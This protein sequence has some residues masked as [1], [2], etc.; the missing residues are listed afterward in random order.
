MISYFKNKPIV[1]SGFL[2]ALIGALLFSTK[3]VIVKHAFMHTSVDAITLLALRMG[4]A[5]PFYIGI[6]FFAGNK[7]TNV[8]FTKRQW[9][10]VIALGLSGYYLSSLWDFV[11]LQYISAGLERLILF[12]YPTLTVL[13][14]AAIF[15]QQISRFQKWA[16]VL[17]YLGIAI[18]YWGEFNFVTDSLNFFKGSFFVFLCAVTFAIYIVGSGRLIPQLGATKFTAYAMLASTVGVVTHYLIAGVRTEHFTPTLLWYGLILGI[19]A[20]V[21]PSFFIS[22]GIKKIGANNVAILSSVGPVS[23]IL[24][25][26]FILGEKMFL[27]QIVGTI[28]VIIGVIL[29]AWKNKQVE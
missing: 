3:A 12:L 28:L 22:N 5:L 6:A 9:F 11:G 26:H 29:I 7:K 25:A 20:T 13:F 1:F 21:I 24:Q 2:V 19:F 4:F 15:K 10:Y 18:A 23:T 14:N 27:E 8:P 17:T 16:L